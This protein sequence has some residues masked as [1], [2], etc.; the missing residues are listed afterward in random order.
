[1]ETLLRRLIKSSMSLPSLLY[2]M[3]LY[4]EH[5]THC[6]TLYIA[7]TSTHKVHH[8]PLCNISKYNALLV[9]GFSTRCT[10]C[11]LPDALL[12]QPDISSLTWSTSAPQSENI[13]IWYYHTLRLCGLVL[14]FHEQEI[15]EVRICFS[16][17]F[18]RRDWLRRQQPLSVVLALC[19]MR[20]GEIENRLSATIAIEATDYRFAK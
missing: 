14:E 5:S 18:C 6:C 1:M 10:S 12:I 2:P 3:S 7:K 9:E 13:F 19:N 4:L 8:L 20:E 11:T 16:L 15:C 17:L